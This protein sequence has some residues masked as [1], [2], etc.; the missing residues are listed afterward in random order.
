MNEEAL[1]G[2]EESIYFPTTSEEE[3]STKNEAALK[4]DEEPFYS[5]IAGDEQ[6]STV[7][8]DDL[9][10]DTEPFYTPAT[11]EDEL[12]IQ[13]EKQRVKKIPRNNIV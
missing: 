1:N 9:K 5:R 11:S 6:P 4:K 12:Y 13:L 10:E 7:N 8:E 3:P 2:N